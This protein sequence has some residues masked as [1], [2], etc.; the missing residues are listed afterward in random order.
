MAY[1]I[2]V[3]LSTID[4]VYGVD[5]FPR[6]NSKILAKSQDIF[7]GGP[8]T[9]ASITFAQLGG[10][11]TLATVIGKHG[12]AGFIRDE[13]QKHSVQGID[14]SSSFQEPPALSSVMVDGTGQRNVVSINATRVLS[15]MAEID[16]RPFEK[17]KI[18]LVDGH[19][20]QASQDWAK[21]AKMRGVPVVLD[22]GSWKTGTEELL[23]NVTTTICSADF[24]PP[25]CSTEEEVF[26]YLQG[27]GV[28]NIVVTRGSEPIRFS[29][30]LITGT[31]QV[32]KVD[33]VDTMGA[34]DI[35]HG[36]FC[37]YAASGLGFVEALGE[38]TTVASES[39]R[40]RGTREWAKTA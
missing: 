6:E 33:V 25:G 17:A 14:L 1:G 13:L 26:K 23:K 7:V 16:Q 31:M 28:K 32:P 27:S 4:I 29:S 11:A 38:A 10:N 40:F 36:A 5:S 3:G 34:G 20:M 15:R 19:Y 24:M 8:A 12:L 18:L 2:F 22:A 35:F 39:C 30:G 9:N 37:Y 21:N